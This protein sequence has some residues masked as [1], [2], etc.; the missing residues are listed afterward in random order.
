MRYEPPRKL[1]S[2][3]SNNPA[4]K[5]E[6]LMMAIVDVSGK[7]MRAAMPAIFTSCL[8]LSRIREDH[9][10]KILSDVARPNEHLSSALLHVIT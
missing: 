4:S 8:L 10:Q 1:S 5:D 2:I 3:L 7:A 6:W 9:P